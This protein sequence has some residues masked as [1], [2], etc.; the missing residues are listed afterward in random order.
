VKTYIN[1]FIKILL[2]SCISFKCFGTSNLIEH[3]VTL[4]AD[5][6][7]HDQENQIFKAEHN[8]TL[9]SEQYTISADQLIY[10]VKK[11]TVVAFGNIII[12]DRLGNVIAGSEMTFKDQFK[13]GVINN[14][15]VR[16]ANPTS[17]VA[18]NKA[19]KLHDNETELE[20]ACYTACSTTQFKDPIWQIKSKYTK[21]NTRKESVVYRNVHFEVFGVPIFFLPYFSHPTPNAKAKTGLLAPNFDVKNLQF[22]VYFRV[23]PNLDF[24]ITPRF[25]KGKV[26]LEGQVRH[27]TQYGQYK[28]DGSLLNDDVTKI[29]SQG[30]IIKNDMILKYHL[31]G[32]GAFHFE[33][34]DA[35]FNTKIT[36]DPAYLRQYHDVYDPYLASSIYFQNIDHA[37]YNKLEA[38]YFQDMRSEK[39]MAKD[40]IA[41]PFVKI[42]RVVDLGNLVDLSIDSNNLY[43][44]SGNEYEAVRSSN[45]LDIAQTY[46]LSNNLIGLNLYNKIDLYKFSYNL[47]PKL[48]YPQKNLS[49]VRYLPEL[50][51][52]WRYPFILDNIILEPIVLASTTLSKY[53]ERN[54]LP[55]DSEQE[56]ESNDLNVIYYNRFS[57]RDNDEH[58]KRI[59]YG[60]N[61]QMI[62]STTYSAFLGKS[63]GN[64]SKQD[65]VGSATINNADS[66]FYYRFNV[67]NNLSLNMHEFGMKY[68]G[69]KLDF[70]TTLFEMNNYQNNLLGAHNLPQK[71][72]NLTNNI[73]YKINENWSFSV[74]NIIDLTSRPSTLIRS[75][76]VTYEYDCVRISAK[77]SDNFTRDN[78]RNIKKSKANIFFKI[79]LKTLNM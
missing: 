54:I 71:V 75:I 27:L 4:F 29:D 59:S 63:H 65:I 13:Y 22:P 67:A 17:V 44:K 76:G 55:I 20:Y 60:L 62:D 70:F 5:N 11:D 9:I 26:I 69:N 79:G 72:S 52:N 47:D 64:K 35:G 28:F 42:K 3:G 77:I 31:F 14:I 68:T 78:S 15:I 36:T 34:F 33:N 57:G 24:T 49:F 43:Y 23:K 66:E 74:N 12:R 46:E 48:N 6:L 39:V 56:F 2:I 8:V 50:H 18:A 58:G 45:V 61:M 53:K 38:L 7:M 51:L 25:T 10:D 1:K 19:T 30:K 40:P 21:I 73:A 32:D 37:D 16:F 41:M